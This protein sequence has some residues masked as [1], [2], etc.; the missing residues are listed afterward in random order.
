M[1]ETDTDR[2]NMITR[3]LSEYTDLDDRHD[4]LKD[5]V[6]HVVGAGPKGD[7]AW[8]T[9]NPDLL[10]TLTDLLTVPGM[11]SSD[12]CG[13]ISALRWLA[14]WTEPVRAIFCI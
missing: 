2:I 5:I 6:Q 14:Q 4:H 9:G 10:S 1:R 13:S 12:A 11:S 7:M 8:V 3:A